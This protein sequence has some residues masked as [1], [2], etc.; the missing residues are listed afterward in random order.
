MR[1]DTVAPQ[2]MHCHQEPTQDELSVGDT[3]IKNNGH[4][5]LAFLAI[6][7]GFKIHCQA[8]DCQASDRTVGLGYRSPNPALF[9][10]YFF[11]CWIKKCIH[12]HTVAS[13]HLHTQIISVLI[14]LSL[15]LSV[16]L[17]LNYYVHGFHLS[18]VGFNFSIYS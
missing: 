12:M 15:I 6:C 18:F 4:F 14:V 8:S 13:E 10:Y 9:Y 3:I 1:L 17:Y 7:S 16:C 5:G 11:L 2:I